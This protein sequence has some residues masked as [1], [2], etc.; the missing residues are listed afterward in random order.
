MNECDLIKR[1]VNMLVWFERIYWSDIIMAIV[2]VYNV[3]SN[4]F[5]YE[6]Q[7]PIQFW[8]NRKCIFDYHSIEQDKSISGK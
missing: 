6:A 7:D 2:R 3:K 5:A 1:S 8:L 4:A